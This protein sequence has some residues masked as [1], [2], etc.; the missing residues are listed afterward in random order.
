MERKKNNSLAKSLAGLAE[1]DRVLMEQWIAEA[2]NQDRA[3]HPSL[4]EYFDWFR[5]RQTEREANPEYRAK[6]KAFR[7][8]LFGTSIIQ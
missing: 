7:Q 8:Q 6:L 1:Q 5:Q 2:E 3:Q 4:Y